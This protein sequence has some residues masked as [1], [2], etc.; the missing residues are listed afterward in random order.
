[1]GDRLSLTKND[2]VDS[3]KRLGKMK[4]RERAVASMTFAAFAWCAG[5]VLAVALSGDFA[6]S[7]MVATASAGVIAVATFTTYT[8]G[9]SRRPT[10]NHRRKR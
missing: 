7:A 2:R 6:L 4:I 3:G 5:M 1:M 10:G 9:C 8:F